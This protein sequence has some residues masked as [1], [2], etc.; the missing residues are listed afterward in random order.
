MSTAVTKYVY[1]SG[2]IWR[3]TAR[4]YRKYISVGCHRT[5]NASDFGTKV[6]ETAFNATRAGPQEFQEERANMGMRDL[7]DQRR[8]WSSYGRCGTCDAGPHEA[9]VSMQKRYETSNPRTPS[10]TDKRWRKTPHPG[11]SRLVN[12]LGQPNRSSRRKP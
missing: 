5:V 11:R 12:E 2:E 6:G 7:A 10:S 4:Q 8:D 3:M 9:C 1:D